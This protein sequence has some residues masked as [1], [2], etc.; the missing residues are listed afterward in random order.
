MQS[1][2]AFWIGQPLFRLPR[3]LKYLPFLRIL[4]VDY[5]DPEVG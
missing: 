5:V 4:V 2:A 3:F 1:F